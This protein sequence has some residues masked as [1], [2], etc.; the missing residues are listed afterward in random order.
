M[1]R[2]VS[3]LLATALLASCSERMGQRWDWNRMRAQPRTTAYGGNTALPGG[4]DLHAPPPGTVNTGEDEPPLR[5][6]PDRGR[7]RYGIFCAVC[8]GEQ[9]DGR[10][11]IALNMASPLPSSLI[12]RTAVGWP[13]ATFDSAMV[14]GTGTMMGFGAD[15]PAEDRRA[16]ISYIRQLQ[17]AVPER[18]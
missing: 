2:L 4:A 1:K 5:F 15:I 6:T 8:H 16:I 3:A 7:E 18:R 12:D 14:H 10:S 9:G 13:D 17:R 11:L